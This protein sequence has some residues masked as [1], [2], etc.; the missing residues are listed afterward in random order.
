M[1]K[2]TKT[3]VTELFSIA[4]VALSTGAAAA[5][6]HWFEALFAWSRH[7]ERYQI[8][9]ILVGLFAAT[10]GVGVFAY[11]RWKELRRSTIAL[12]QANRRAVLEAKERHRKE[13]SLRH[14]EE[15][16]ADMATIGA[17]WLWETDHLLRFSY[18]SDRYHEIT[19]LTRAEAI[20]RARMEIF[21]KHIN[22]LQQAEQHY[23]DLD[24]RRPFED[25]E[26]EWL[27]PDGSMR[28][29]CISG[30]PVFDQHNWFI[31]Y[32]GVGRDVTERRQA[33]HALV[34]NERRFRDFCET[35]ADY[36]WETDAEHR[37]RFLSHRF[38][39]I[40]GLNPEDVIGKTRHEVWS[41]QQISKGIW[42]KFFAILDERR[43]FRNFQVRW[44][45]P[46]KQIRVLQIS[47]Q[48]VFDQAD[49]FR[50]YRGAVQDLTS[51]TQLADTMRY[52]ATHDPLTQLP[53]RLEFD[54]RL[55]RA[56]LTAQQQNREHVLCYLDL[57]QF[58]IVNDTVGHRAGDKVLKKVATL[59]RSKIRRHDTIARLGGDEFALLMLDCS[60][61]QAVHTSQDLLSA[62]SMQ[63]FSWRRREFEIGASIGVVPITPKTKS[64]T[65]VLIQSDVAC[66]TAKD[67][68]RNRVYV[69]AQDAV[70]PGT[71]RELFQT[72][73]L[74]DAIRRDRLVLYSQP[75]KPL[76]TN[77]QSLAYH[78]V[79]IRLY[80]QQGQ[81]AL[82][83]PF[84]RAAER[85]GL[86]ND[87]DEWVIRNALKE[88]SEVSGTIEDMQGGISINLSAAS[89]ANPRI[90]EI[91]ISRIHEYGV[92]A[93]K[94]C[95]EVTESAAIHNL[96]HA[97]SVIE[98]L[99]ELG[100]RFALDDFGKGF[101]AFNQLK[102]LPVNYLKIDASLVH[103]IYNIEKDRTIVAAIHQMSK[104]MGISTVAE[105]V[106]NL[107]TLD[108]LRNI[109]IDFVQ[110]Q[111]V[112]KPQPFAIHAAICD[113]IQHDTER[114]VA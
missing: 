55:K 54:S 43:S 13:E 57:D 63:T 96:K 22:D 59:L 112:G 42:K 17:H 50:G 71:H 31:G 39:T 14:S 36:F 34:E 113:N 108:V 95:F 65:N 23:A 56:V 73:E 44:Q 97:A 37:F 58:K 74:K 80:D 24:A 76:V 82:P 105:G 78:E 32:R 6:W 79:L 49:I 107:N 62:V 16:F 93:S 21:S 20:G 4:L 3:R 102:S 61:S 85:F 28:I 103:D 101:S 104:A 86:M 38:S 30:R 75:V 35:A 100:C 5:Y 40:T 1:S 88:F 68:G 15:R 47:G 10:L 60:I 18:L 67:L 9:A 66:Y 11:R 29:L 84:I 70:V 99:C 90:T 114:A 25:V 87:L 77:P 64:A 69:Y 51:E 19:G 111:A 109:G 41:E 2:E 53:N 98:R 81:M 26:F 7:Y 106:S 48:P 94:V 83:G 91:I 52:R 45:R 110:G 8:D 46:D 92:D 33:E 72:L 27:R 12:A 89:L